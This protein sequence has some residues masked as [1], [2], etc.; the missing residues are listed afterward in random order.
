MAGEDRLRRVEETKQLV[1]MAR[2]HG[3]IK[4]DIKPDHL[5]TPEYARTTRDALLAEIRS[6]YDD[7]MTDEPAKAFYRDLDQ[8]IRELIEEEIKAMIAAAAHA[9]EKEKTDAEHFG[10]LAGQGGDGGKYVSHGPV[11]QLQPDQYLRLAE[12]IKRNN[13]NMPANEL[14]GLLGMQLVGQREIGNNSGPIVQFSL[15]SPGQPWCAGF[16][17]GLYKSIGYDNIYDHSDYRMANSYMNN[18]S[19]AF[20]RGAQ[21]IE[22]GDPITFSMP[23]NASGAHV[24]IAVKKEQEGGRTKVYYVAGNESD[25]VRLRWFYEDSPPR[26]MIGYT[27]TREVAKRKGIDL[28]ITPPLAAA[29][30]LVASTPAVRENTQPAP[31]QRV[32]FESDDRLRGIASVLAAVVGIPSEASAADAQ[33]PRPVFTVADNSGRAPREVASSTA[34]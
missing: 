3:W 5:A 30:D 25:M 31:V 19:Y 21:G 23:G 9:A 6:K 8:R 11:N 24:G 2:Q 1:I 14:V 29:P 34:V 16:L 17:R 32:A 20:H 27:S 28:N 13:P 12:D 18:Y 22:V 7:P 33:T 10:H 15:C 4:V 26:G